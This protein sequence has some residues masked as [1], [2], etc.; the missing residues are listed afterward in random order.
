[1]TRDNRRYRLVTRMLHGTIYTSSFEEKYST[2]ESLQEKKDA[3]H[4]CKLTEMTN[5]E[6]RF[7]SQSQKK[8]T[9]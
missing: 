3:N 1:M 8:I 5:P 4:N 9:T 2:A 6:Q 7:E